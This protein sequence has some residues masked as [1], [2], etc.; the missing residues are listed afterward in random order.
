MINQQEIIILKGTKGRI[1][2]TGAGD[3]AAI[4]QA[5]ERNKGLI[6]KNYAPSINWESEINNI[7][8][9]CA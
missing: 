6:F 3:D 1:A 5:D 4:R 8:I 7:D 2:I 9:D